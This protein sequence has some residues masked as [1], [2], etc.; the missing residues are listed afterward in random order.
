MGPSMM[1]Y[2][3]LKGLLA[4]TA[5]AP[6]CSSSARRACNEGV[7]SRVEVFWTWL[8]LSLCGL[9]GLVCFALVG[10]S[11]VGFWFW[12]GFPWVLV[13][14]V[15]FGLVWFGLVWLVWR[16][17]FCF[18]LL[19][20]AFGFVL[21]GFC[22]ASLCWLCLYCYGT[23][24]G[25][26]IKTAAAE[27]FTREGRSSW[28]FGLALPSRSSGIQSLR[29]RKPRCYVHSCLMCFHTQRLGAHHL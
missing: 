11:L 28:F 9:V 5:L 25:R 7:S 2:S 14:L 29:R 19:W 18:G 6:S 16:I 1:D 26:V 13:C 22:H 17:L 4:W 23:A 8:V 3:P 15:W 21:I 12:C 10:L 20:F 24:R 27:S